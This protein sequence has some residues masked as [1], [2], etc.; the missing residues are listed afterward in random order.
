MLLFGRLRHG[1]GNNIKI[2]RFAVKHV[3][4]TLAHNSEKLIAL[5]I[6]LRLNVRKCFWRNIKAQARG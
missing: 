1:G 4:I 3:Q 5:L 2:S 6:S